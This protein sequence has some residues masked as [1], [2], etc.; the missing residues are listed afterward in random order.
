[1]SRYYNCRVRITDGQAAALVSIQAASYL[2]PIPAEDIVLLAQF[3]KLH[4]V[5][6]DCWLNIVEEP[7][8][9]EPVELEP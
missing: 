3:L 6:T 1:M 4:G 7:E 5:E 9:V 8:S 2:E